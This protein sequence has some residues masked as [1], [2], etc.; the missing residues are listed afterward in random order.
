VTH[1]REAAFTLLGLSDSEGIK[2][3]CQSLLSGEPAP[4]PQEA[5]DRYGTYYAA[6]LRIDTLAGEPGVFYVGWKRDDPGDWRIFAYA[7]EAP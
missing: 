5:E 7:V 3:D 1:P 2:A 6:A 4:T